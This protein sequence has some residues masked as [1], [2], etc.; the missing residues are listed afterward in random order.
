[1]LRQ[2]SIPTASPMAKRSVTSGQEELAAS[3]GVFSK[4]GNM[5]L[6]DEQRA[7]YLQSPYECPFCGVREIDALEWD[8]ELA[9]QKITC[10]KCCRSWWDYYK[11]VDVEEVLPEEEG[12][13]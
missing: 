5:A 3:S 6:T 12:E 7:K 10:R 9:A 13:I 11:L 1:M 4:G 8:G 2:S